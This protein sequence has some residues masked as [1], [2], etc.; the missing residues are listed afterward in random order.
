MIQE[1]YDPERERHRA[2]WVSNFIGAAAAV[3][4]IAIYGWMGWRIAK[5]HERADRA[6]VGR[7]DPV[8]EMA[9]YRGV[10]HAL[11]TCGDRLHEQQVL[12]LDMKDQV[13]HWNY[14]ARITHTVDEEI[15]CQQLLDRA[16][17]DFR[18]AWEED[19]YTIQAQVEDE[20]WC[21]SPVG[22]LGE[23]GP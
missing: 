3:V 20:C 10:V 4:L 16:T 21:P 5:E 6:E 13:D 23:V 8:V 18:W 11:E 2:R 12:T 14:I 17:R 9:E 7:L 19:L 22:G 15:Q 1:P